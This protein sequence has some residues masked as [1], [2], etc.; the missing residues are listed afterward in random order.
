MEKL[1]IHEMHRFVYL[2]QGQ[3]GY[4]FSS[5]L[6]TSQ[7]KQIILSYSQGDLQGDRDTLTSAFFISR[8]WVD[9]ILRN[10]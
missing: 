5:I 6:V 2:P 10:P 8:T 9:L 4:R 7:S 3:N 1:C